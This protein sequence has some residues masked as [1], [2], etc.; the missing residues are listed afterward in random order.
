MGSRLSVRVSEWT[1]SYQEVTSGLSRSYCRPE[2]EAST[3]D[4]GQGWADKDLAHPA[5]EG[6]LSV[7][8]SLL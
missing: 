7:V 8:T 3:E 4:G 6:L 5:C 2:D 1:W